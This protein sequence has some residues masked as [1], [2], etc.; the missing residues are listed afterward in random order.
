MNL[1]DHRFSQNADQKFEGFLPFPL[2][3]FRSEILQIFGCHFGRNDDLIISFWIQ[4]TFGIF[5]YKAGFL[6]LILPFKSNLIGWKFREMHEGKYVII[7]NILYLWCTKNCSCIVVAVCKIPA[8][9]HKNL[10]GHHFHCGHRYHLR[11]QFLRVDQPK[12]KNR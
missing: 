9:I 1:W 2:I 11:I 5:F 10:F 7:L 12:I 6:G 8:K 4:L 3:N